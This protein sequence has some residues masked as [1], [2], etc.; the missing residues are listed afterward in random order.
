LRDGRRCRFVL[1]LVMLVFVLRTGA[2]A[3]GQG[4]ETRGNCQEESSRRSA[5]IHGWNLLSVGGPGRPEW[6]GYWHGAARD[7]QRPEQRFQAH[8]NV[9]VSG[10]S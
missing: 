6:P 8:G 9:R 4:R 2:S 1:V 10:V 3:G 5:G 7:L